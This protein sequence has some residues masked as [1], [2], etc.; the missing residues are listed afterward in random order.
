MRKHIRI[1]EILFKEGLVTEEQLKEAIEVQK[2]EGG[3][4]GEILI[5]L[6][7]VKEEQIIAVLSKQLSIPYA[8][9]GSGKLEPVNDESLKELIP[10]EFAIRHL[11]LPIARNLN[12]LTVALYDPLD[13]VLIDNLK[14]LTGCE[15]NPIIASRQDITTAIKK[16]YKERM[17]RTV[18]EATHQQGMKEE[19][20][21]ALSLDELIAKSEETPVVRLVDLIIKQAI[22][23]SASDIHIEPQR[24]KLSLRYRID[25]VLYEVPPPSKNLQLPLI[26]RI[27][28]L[29]RMNIAEKRLPQDGGFMVRI[30]D[31]LIDLRTSSIPTIYGEKIVIRILDKSRVPLHLEKL[32]FSPQELRLIRAGISFP[33]GLI[34][35]TGPTGSGKSTTLYALLRELNSPEKNILTIEDPVEY[36]LDGI[37]QVQVRPEIGLTFANVLRSFLRQDPD[38][39]MVGEIR[40]LETAE[41][42]VR[43]ALTGH[44]VLS[45]LHT[46]NSVIAVTRLMDMGIPSYLLASALRLIVAQRL[47]RKLCPTCKEPYEVKKEALPEGV[48]LNSQVIYKPKGCKDCGYI[49]FK[50]RTA[51]GEVLLLDEELQEAIYRRVFS[52][53]IMKLAKQ[54]GTQILLESGLR[55]VEEGITSLEE[56]LSITTF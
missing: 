17:L 44:I 29:S 38:I 46:N 3:K 9:I 50:G 2:K 56:V 1:G 31:R 49:G 52:S 12:S 10:Y 22:E 32:G 5:R 48:R 41:I 35:L 19:E 33:Y 21:E 8:T 20:E 40:D 39:I 36:R 26:S 43:A 27:K 37:N 7:Y 14:K 13:L 30:E 4:L 28:I 16:Y 6:N 51:I 15:I 42:C 55:K 24:D 23:E 45:S 11:V 54:K 53:E 47:A 18:I 34:L 25:G